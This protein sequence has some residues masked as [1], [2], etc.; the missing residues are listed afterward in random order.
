[1][2]E[3][4]PEGQRIVNDLAQRYSI[5][6][7]AV[8]HML[9]AVVNGN[10]SMA[11]FNHPEFGGSGQWMRGGMTMVGDMFNSA[12]KWRVESLCTEISTLLGNQPGLLQ[13]G[14]FQS[15]S[16][17]SGPHPIV[18]GAFLRPSALFVPD[19]KSQWYPTEL[20]TPD[21]YGSQNDVRYAYFAKA[22]RLAVEAGGEVCVYDTQ[23]HRISGFSQQQGPSGSNMFTS[24]FG[25]VPL[26]SLRVV[27]RKGKPVAETPSTATTRPFS[28]GGAP[29]TSAP[30]AASD[31]IFTAIER[32]GDLKAKGFLSEEEFAAKKAELL[33]R[34]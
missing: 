9:I 30:K 21:A 32:L 5:S 15:Q 18:A 19:P 2:P 24:Q 33:G 25:N 29:P 6:P 1:M 8:T 28:P 26:E 16:Q 31:E 27:S 22:R 10:G 12:L 3:L 34:L 23:D 7:D 17:S 11:Q 20:G 4:T 13:T 14:S